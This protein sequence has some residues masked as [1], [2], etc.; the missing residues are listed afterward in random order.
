MRRIA[1]LAASIPFA[2]G[3]AQQSTQRPAA[4]T[5][6]QPLQV[7]LQRPIGGGLTYSLSE[8][9]YVAI[10]A[11]SRSGGVGLVHPTFVSQVHLASRAGTNQLTV[12]GR[13]RAS[14]YNVDRSV[15]QSG[16]LAPADAY[17]I[18]ASK[19]PLLAVAEMI[20]SPRVL[21]TFVDQ[22]R[23]A[24]LSSAG[25]AIGAALTEGLF[26][27]EWAEDTYYG[28]R[29]PFQSIAARRNAFLVHCPPIG[30]NSVP[31]TSTGQCERTGGRQR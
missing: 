5:A 22:F 15:E 21:G 3:C 9:A 20:R 25:E 14:I 27:G 29:L 19:L 26:D 30:T 6:D 24:G 13:A 2:L 1:L 17:Y 11:I 18:I 8:P 4:V 28:S 31:M 12:D 10:F 23:A 16:I 7:Q